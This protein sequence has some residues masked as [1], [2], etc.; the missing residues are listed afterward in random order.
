VDGWLLK[1]TNASHH[2][3]EHFASVA[4]V[5]LASAMLVLSLIPR[6]AI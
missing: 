2:P 5:I 3:P 1:G 6:R 4:A